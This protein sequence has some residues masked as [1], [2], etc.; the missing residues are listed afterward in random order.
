[1]N[2]IVSVASLAS[3]AAIA[4][5]AASG[6]ADPIFDVISRWKAALAEHD[7]L[8]AEDSPAFKKAA[9][10]FLNL[11]EELRRA[12]PTTPEG[13]LAKITLVRENPDVRDWFDDGAGIHPALDYMLSVEKSLR[14]MIERKALLAMAPLASVSDAVAPS[15]MDERLIDLGRQFEPIYAE[16]LDHLDRSNEDHL[17]FERRAAIAAGLPD[18]TLAMIKAGSVTEAQQKAFNSVRRRMIDDM[19]DECERADEERNDLDNR[20]EP[21]FREIMS[22]E[23]KTLPGLRTK[24]MA[25][26]AWRHDIF[27]WSVDDDVRNV[28]KSAFEIC[29]LDRYPHSS[30]A[31]VELQEILGA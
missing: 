13:L 22:L 4:A 24:L 28:I 7:R 23:P 11:C 30:P 15:P 31:S 8:F 16:M 2:T 19:S 27:G 29:G 3:A 6:V 9:R 18:L 14:S 25:L 10:A 20:I 21:F 1:M 12:V 17:A 5:P 26:A